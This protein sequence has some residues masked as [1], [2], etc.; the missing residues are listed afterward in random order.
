MKNSQGFNKVKKIRLTHQTLVGVEI[1]EMGDLH[2]AIVDQFVFEF[3]GI[4]TFNDSHSCY[5]YVSRRDRK[6]FENIIPYTVWCGFASASR[7]LL[8]TANE[9]GF[10]GKPVDGDSIHDSDAIQVLLNMT[11]ISE[12]R[13][14][15]LLYA[16]AL[17]KIEA[18][19]K[20][21]PPSI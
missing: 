7:Y 13:F 6:R 20:P 16:V 18:K 9:K 12:Q 8:C 4:E 1:Q 5:E 11:K 2:R 19:N 10:I 14:I 21:I 3:D 17:I 15:A